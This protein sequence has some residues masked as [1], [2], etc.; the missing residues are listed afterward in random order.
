MCVGGWM[1]DVVGAFPQRQRGR[2]WSSSLREVGCAIL[3]ALGAAT[4]ALLQD[5]R[6]F[7]GAQG[8]VQ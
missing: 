7:T 2:W 1:G 8:A 4:S 5:E 6:P 3:H